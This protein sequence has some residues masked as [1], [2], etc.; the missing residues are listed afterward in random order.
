MLVEG[1]GSMGLK[2]SGKLHF[3]AYCKREGELL[4]SNRRLVLGMRLTWKDSG[5]GIPGVLAAEVEKDAMNMISII[6]QN[7]LSCYSL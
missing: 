3:E 1:L 5:G 6:T 7:F 2:S 4:V